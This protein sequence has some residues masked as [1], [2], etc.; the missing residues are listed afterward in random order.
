MVQKSALL[1]KY[2]DLYNKKPTSRVFAPLA[3]TYRKLGMYDEALNILKNG[4]RYNSTY[5][6]GYIILGNCYY[7]LEKYDHAYEVVR[8]FVKTNLDN[9]SLQKLF[10][11]ICEKI[12]RP[13]EALETYKYLLFV[14]PKDE[15]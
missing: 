15:V 4:I 11:Q 5:P 6:L 1:T 7:D 8:P 14:N 2:L 9:I 3:E 10:A 13:E 12:N